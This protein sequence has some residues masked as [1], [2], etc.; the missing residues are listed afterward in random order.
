LVP[1][2]YRPL[3]SEEVL[4]GSIVRYVLP[5]LI[6][7]T[8]LGAFVMC[9]LVFR[10][11][12][13]GSDDEPGTRARNL[14]ALRFGHAFAAVTFA[15][16]AVLSVA[17]A[18]R[19]LAVPTPALGDAQTA[20]PVIT[21]SAVAP[22]S[23]TEPPAAVPAPAAPP[24]DHRTPPPPAEVTPPQP[25]KAAEV[26]PQRATGARERDRRPASSDGAVSP[27]AATG[28]DDE[29]RAARSSKSV[30]PPAVTPSRPL[31]LP[32]TDRRPGDRA[33][34]PRR[35]ES[36]AVD[37]PGDRNWEAPSALPTAAASPGSDQR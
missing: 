2:K 21:E 14:T 30:P 36:R 1:S 37:I 15:V 29:T 16:A 5:A 31:E 17:V 26:P 11:G 13:P 20:P 24:V 4:M 10:Y 9:V 23:S 25:A 22:A 12:L 6:A 7:V 33:L 18:A 32:E 27:R 19:G 28:P 35:D 34:P 8:S 3:V